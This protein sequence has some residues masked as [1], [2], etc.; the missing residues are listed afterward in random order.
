MRVRYRPPSRLRRT[1]TP[2]PLPT[3]EG[4]IKENPHDHARQQSA[5]S[6]PHRRARLRQPGSRAR[7]EPPRFRA[8]RRGRPAPQRRIVAT[9]ASRRFHGAGTGRRRARR[10]PR[11]RADARHG[12]AGV[13]SRCDRAEPQTRRGAAV[14]A[15]LQRAFQADRSAQRHRRGDGGAERPRRAG[16][17]RVCA[18]ARRAVPVR[19]AAGRQ[20]SRRGARARYADG[21]GGGRA[22]LIRTDFKEETETDLFGEQAVLC[23][24]ASALVQAGFE[25]LVEAG[26]QPEI[27]YYEVMHELKLIVDL[28]YEGGITKMLEFV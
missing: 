26:Y 20:R 3:G 10:G 18:R 7:A 12:A 15:R 28:F 23:G 2:T 4:L 17:Q 16:A 9:R 11:R 22:M 14:R 13:V 5:R 8:R 6:I 24:G 19:G 27:A 1:L 25:T 21:I